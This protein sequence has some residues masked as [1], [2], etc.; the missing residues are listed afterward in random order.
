MV[1]DGRARVNAD[2]L[3]YPTQRAL[4]PVSAAKSSFVTGTLMLAAKAAGGRVR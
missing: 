1:R 2:V 3:T 4:E